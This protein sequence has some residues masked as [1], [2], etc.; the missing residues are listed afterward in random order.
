VPYAGT[1]ESAR[2]SILILVAKDGLLTTAPFPRSLRPV[3]HGHFVSYDMDLVFEEKG[4][5]MRVVTTEIDGA[6]SV[7]TRVYPPRLSEAELAKYTGVYTSPELE[8]EYK[9]SVE[10]GKLVL[11]QGWRPGLPLSP[12]TQD[13]F[14]GGRFTLVF[15]RGRGGKPSGFEVFADRAGGIAFARQQTAS[16]PRTPN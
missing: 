6:T 7:A 14:S 2:H 3:S 16:R 15:R 11:H 13:E 1:Y 9:L 12:L 10:E 5:Q 4:A 8:A